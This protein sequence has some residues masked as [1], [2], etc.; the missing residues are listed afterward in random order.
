MGKK[1]KFH[2]SL[3]NKSSVILVILIAIFLVCSYTA[4]ISKTLS[5]SVLNNAIK[6]STSRTDTMYEGVV[7]FITTEDFTEINSSEDKDSDI[8]QNLQAHLNEVRSMNSTRYF[9][10]AKKDSDGNLIYLVDGLSQNTTDFRN[11]GDLIE[12]EMIPYITRALN[13]ETVYSNDIVDTDWGHIFTACYPIY[14][15]NSN[16]VLG[17][18]C[19]ETDME[20]TYSFIAEHQKSLI[21][22]A[23]IAILILIFL[24][25]VATIFTNKYRKVKKQNEQTLLDSYQRLER[26]LARERKHTEII[27]TLATIY[28]TIITANLNDHSFEII[29]SPSP[30]ENI[31]HDKTDFDDVLDDLLDVFVSDEYKE[32]IREF[33]KFDTLAYRLK[34]VNTI[35]KEYKSRNGRWFQARIIVKKRNEVGAVSD[36]IYCARDFTD[37]KKRELELQEKLK[38]SAIEAKK[39]NVSK[40]N[41]LRRMSHDIRT[42]L[43]GIVGMLHI[44][45]TNKGNQ[46]K[47]D[48]CYEKIHHSIDYLLD[49]V[50]NVLDISK[51][52][53][54][55]LELDDKP[56][57]L[58]EM[59]NRILPIVE[60][61]AN[62]YGIKFEGGSSTSHII[63]KNIIG[64]S[65]LLNR[66][67]MNIGSN[68][69]KYN[70]KGGLIRLSCNEIDYD[71]D[72]ATYEFVCKDTGL[73]MSKEFQKHA[74]EPFS[75]E[76]KET[77]TSFSGTGLG[78]SIVKEVV[79]LMG[80][81]INLQS[82]EGVG[83]TITLIIPFKIDHNPIKKDDVQTK[84][85]LDL[86]NKKALLVEDNELNM[87]IAK[88]ILEEEG[89]IIECARDG[90]EALEVFEKSDIN[91]F[92]Y[93]FMDMMMPVMDGI[94]STK[95]IRKLNRDDAKSVPIIAMT[96]NA[97]AEDKK[98][99][100]NAGMNGHIGKPIDI[101]N[102]KDVLASLK[103]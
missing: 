48:E 21:R 60:S 103:K 42:P 39:A 79:E 52:E 89:M 72:T 5:D 29:E 70:Q 38:A 45:E 9:Y 87:E 56:F 2:F 95:A 84:T 51:L 19:I 99:C 75:R 10:T 81:T 37:E 6:E 54:G 30:I 32:E 8:Y 97:F 59:L 22:S 96:A 50:N 93:I 3:A 44:A 26:V 90:K 61:N 25:S 16:N 67:L 92:D 78:L 65:T 55:S 71:E 14:E 24:I 17:A 43:N 80:G 98:A 64:S 53:S 86:A 4:S 74:F 49:I 77:T 73:G 15:P 91:H 36:V 46:E 83:T 23:A 33:L 34:N 40:T 27:N 31:A 12:E 20:S 82:V 1:K 76:G 101:K 11:P 57:D 100:L 88:V 7:G 18:L 35:M 69:I 58:V 94:A 28:T 13:G 102:I 85:D 66:A 41:F 47:V 62:E 63:H 68:S